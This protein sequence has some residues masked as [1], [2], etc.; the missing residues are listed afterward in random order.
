M[1]Q[2]STFSKIQM[3][4]ASMFGAKKKDL[5]CMLFYQCAGFSKS[6]TLPFLAK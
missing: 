1:E 2:V 5:V 6:Q 4:V 3:A